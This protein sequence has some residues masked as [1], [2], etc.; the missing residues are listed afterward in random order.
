M[1]ACFVRKAVLEAVEAS[2]NITVAM[3]EHKSVM[4][5]D[6]K[7]ET[8]PMAKLG[9]DNIEFNEGKVTM[10]GSFLNHRMMQAQVIAGCM[11]QLDMLMREI[12]V[13]E[14]MAADKHSIVATLSADAQRLLASHHEHHQAIQRLQ[15]RVSELPPCAIVYG[16]TQEVLASEAASANINEGALMH[17][18][19]IMQ[20]LKL[21]LALGQ[22]VKDLKDE[23]GEAGSTAMR[24]PFDY[25]KATNT[26][27]GIAKRLADLRAHPFPSI[28][29]RL[30]FEAASNYL[31]GQ[32]RGYPGKN[33]LQAREH[34]YKEGLRTLTTAMDRVIDAVQ[35]MAHG[36]DVA[37]VQLAT[38]QDT[39]YP[40]DDTDGQVSHARELPAPASPRREPLPQL[41]TA[42]EEEEVD[43]TLRPAWGSTE[44]TNTGALP[45]TK[46]AHTYTL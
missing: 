18:E 44:G 16:R 20:A 33:R 36:K 30:K 29:P 31:L 37:M 13:L 43:D 46:R 45:D 12:E 26:I 40:Q 5:L 9:G 14:T 7:G 22:R 41:A 21:G 1:A 32:S 38:E 24:W 17:C 10:S 6:V 3:S 8:A 4:I 11:E 39:Q 28:D 2:T 27:S 34:R 23:L 35:D 42:F 19:N 25:A 15:D